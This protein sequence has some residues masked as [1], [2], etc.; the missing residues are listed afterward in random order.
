MRIPGS[1]IKATS[2]VVRD[3]A[4][5]W[6]EFRVAR[7]ALGDRARGARSGTWSSNGSMGVLGPVVADEA[8][9]GAAAWG[10]ILAAQ[11]VGLVV[12]GLITLRLKPRRP[13]LF[14]QLSVLL[15]GLPIARLGARAADARDRLLAPSSRGSGSSS[16]ASTGTRRSSSTSLRSRSPASAR[17]TRSGSFVAIP[18]GLSIAGPVSAAIGVSSTLW[19]AFAIFVVAQSATLLSRDVR[20]LRR[21]DDDVELAPTPEVADVTS[22]P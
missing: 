13:L 14:A 12:G 19:L 21:L 15:W 16:S 9:G 10:F 17:T 20:T 6:K 4:D 11:A 3:L 8:L 18:I 7:V 22:S 1:L 2:S 5:G